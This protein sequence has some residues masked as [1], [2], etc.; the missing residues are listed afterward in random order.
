MFKLNT[1]FFKLNSM[2][3]EL[4]IKAKISKLFF[5]HKTLKCCIYLA[6]QFY[7]LKFV[8][9]LTYICELDRFNTQYSWA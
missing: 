9:N 6:N 1:I 5:S 2:E 7:E 3:C 4:Y 8:G